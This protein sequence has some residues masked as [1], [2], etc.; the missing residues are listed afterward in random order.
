MAHE[1]TYVICE[2]M[3]MEE[4]MTKEQIKEL[5]GAVASGS[6]KGVYATAA[7]LKTANPETGVYIATSNGHIYSWTKNSTSDPIDL[8]VYQAAEDSDTVEEL[9]ED[10]SKIVIEPINLLSENNPDVEINL[11]HFFNSVDNSIVLRDG[12]FVACLIK[13]K[14]NK[15]YT[16]TRVGFKCFGVASNKTTITEEYVNHQGT[17]ANTTITTGANTEYVALNFGSN[18]FNN[19]AMFA[20]GDTLPVNYVP[21]HKPYFGEI[22]LNDNQINQVITKIETKTN[23]IITVKKDGT[24]DF[25]TIKGAVDSISDASIDNGYDIHIYNGTYDVIEELGGQNYINSI[26]SSQSSINTGI[27]LPPFV[28]LI[29]IGEVYITAYGDNYTPNN[30]FGNLFS[31]INVQGSNI[32]KNLH[33]WV[34]NCRYAVHDETNGD[35]KFSRKT[36]K[37]IGC[38]IRHNGNSQV[39]WSSPNA[40]AVGFDSGDEFNFENCY[41][42]SGAGNAL[43]FHDRASDVEST[44][45]NITSCNLNS[46]SM[47]TLKFGSVGS[48]YHYVNLNDTYIN[49]GIQ[50]LHE[51]GGSWCNFIL[52][53]NTNKEI[54][55]SYKNNIP[56]I[57]NYSKIIAYDSTLIENGKFIAN[58]I[59]NQMVQTTKINVA[60]GI[61]INAEQKIMQQYGYIP[62]NI[63][64]QE[65]LNVGDTICYDNG[66]IVINGTNKFAIYDGKFSG[67]ALLKLPLLN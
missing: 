60:I 20:K 21:Y 28:N 29:G 62:I 33:I 49:K 47:N 65:T 54:V 24:G 51:S 19:Y 34:N 26:T 43:S 23:N 25:T 7:A 59:S 30:N 15:K 14:P 32:L 44:L 46:Q 3:C 22:D 39:S 1:K 36:R 63:L 56:L 41:M 53:G 11:N 64:T 13:V 40:Y 9:K 61:V 67:Y 35:Y 38:D 17:S 2:N 4:G 6:P 27:K 50:L 58:S 48:A 18:Y 55:A 8:G 16:F 31:P 10:L 66:S 45:I 12:S 42:Y 5:V 52:K 57:Q 37:V